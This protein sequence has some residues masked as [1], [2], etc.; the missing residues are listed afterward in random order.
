MLEGLKMLPIV[1][2]LLA[3]LVIFAIAIKVSRSVARYGAENL[4]RIEESHEPGTAKESDFMG[5]CE[6]SASRNVVFHKV[7]D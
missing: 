2:V 4:M 1:L 5:T 7:E 6:C 3:C